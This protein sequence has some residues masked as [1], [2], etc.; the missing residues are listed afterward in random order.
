VPSKYA[1]NAGGAA[2]VTGFADGF[3]LL[4]ASHAS[5]RELN[6]RVLHKHTASNANGHAAGP[7]LPMNRFRPNIAVDGPALV[8]FR[9]DRMRRLRVGI[10]AELFGVKK[11]SRCRIPTTDQATGVQGG[12]S[13][14]PLTTLR[15]FREIQRP[16]KDPAVYFGLNLVHRRA[17]GFGGW[18]Q[19]VGRALGI[20]VSDEKKTAASPPGTILAVGDEVHVLEEGPIPPVA[21]GVDNTGTLNETEEYGTVGS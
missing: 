5:L 9:E 16:D 1:V 3:P 19:R 20:P 11:C 6:R 13:A 10:D 14:E 4:L 2:D 8:P 17:Q 12:L 21:D 7:E 15:T 18:L